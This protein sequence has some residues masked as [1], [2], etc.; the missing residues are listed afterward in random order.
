[1]F[2]LTSLRF[3][4]GISL[5]WPLLWILVFDRWFFW[6]PIDLLVTFGIPI[7]GWLVWWKFY[8]GNGEK[9][10]TEGKL[11][12]AKSTISLN[13]LKKQVAKKRASQQ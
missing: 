6:T 4:I 9:L 10:L 5:A 1:M 7:A 13:K 8:E 2:E 3:W 11:L 12:L